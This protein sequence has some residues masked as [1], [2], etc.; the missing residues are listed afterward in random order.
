[1][2]AIKL[3]GKGLNK[4]CEHIVLGL[5]GFVTIVFNFKIRMGSISV[6]WSEFDGI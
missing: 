3:V 1:M 4:H 2:T 5:Q 6:A